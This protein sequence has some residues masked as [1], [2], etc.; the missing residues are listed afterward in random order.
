MVSDAELLE[1]VLRLGAAAGC[2][3]L[4]AHDPAEARRSWKDVPLVVLDA[5]AA[6]RCTESGL[7]RRGRVVVAV[8]GQ[9]SAVVWEQAVEVGAE[10]VVSLPEAE[11]WLVAAL[12]EAAEGG[13]G[14]GA[15]L[16]VL[17]GRGGAGASV[18][19]AAVAVTAVRAGDRALL[20]DCD[21]LGGGVDLVLGAEDLGGLRWPGVGV[22]DGRVRR[23]PCMPRC[24]RRTSAAA[25]R[26]G[27]P[28]CRA[29]GRRTGRRRRPSAP[30]S[31]QAAGRAR[32]WCAT[33]RATRRTPRSRQYG[34]RVR[35][36]ASPGA[37]GVAW[38]PRDRAAAAWPAGEAPVA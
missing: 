16:A 9:P 5:A 25:A 14:D 10:H 4:T 22:G 35:T 8:C 6:R 26:A 1:A 37:P 11:S 2:E 31:R 3:L 17:G 18:L 13:R 21:P 15:V 34:V 27:W 32:R 24:P 23:P 19:A 28:C 20:V 38:C 7:P 33:C 12:A 36:T 29:T 30:C